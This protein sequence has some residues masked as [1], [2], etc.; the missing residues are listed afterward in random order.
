MPPK[1]INE[2]MKNIREHKG[3]NNTKT[4]TNCIVN[5]LRF[6][7]SILVTGCTFT[8]GEL[9]FL[10]ND[11]WPPS[12]TSFYE[13]Q[14]R[15]AQLILNFAKQSCRYWRSLLPAKS[16]IAF[17]GSWSHRRNADFCLVDFIDVATGRVVDFE[18]ISK[19]YGE[20]KFTGPSN[21]MEVEGIRRMIPRWINDK[22]IIAYVHDKDS[23]SRKLINQLGWNVTEIIDSNHAVKSLRRKFQKIKVKSPTK[24]RGLKLPLERFFHCLLKLDVTAEEKK[25]YW[26]NVEQHFSGNHSN[27]IEHKETKPWKDI[28]VGNNRKVLKEFLEK[29]SVLFDKCDGIH[30]TQACESLHAVKA[31]FA[32]KMIS[33]KSSWCAR[34]CASILDINEMYWSMK[35]YD[36]LQL[37]PLT[38]AIKKKLMDIDLN[39]WKLRRIRHTEQYKQVERLRR[40]LKRQAYD[41][42]NENSLYKGVQKKKDDEE[43]SSQCNSQR[44]RKYIIHKMP[45][46]IRNLSVWF[47]KFGFKGTAEDEDEDDSTFYNEEE[48][49]E[50]WMEEKE[51]R[52]EEEEVE[53]ND[54]YEKNE[55]IEELITEDYSNLII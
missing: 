41:K 16:I 49:E 27:C 39:K 13:A 28:D 55:N 45:K 4:E 5:A 32:P 25:K 10:W 38:P 34:V 35:L 29:T 22:R 36:Q 20:N 6:T 54:H 18:I 23:K 46:V 52:M 11:I 30:S 51:E 53:V 15:I 3:K 31:H 1:K 9:L 47:K 44:S 33:W 21:A 26:M 12:K 8:Q 42:E 37:P 40:F 2:K 7:F 14:K 50:E 19:K 48:E 43:D 24:L 17:D